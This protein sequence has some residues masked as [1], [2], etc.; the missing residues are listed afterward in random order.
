MRVSQVCSRLIGEIQRY[1][2]RSGSTAL[3]ITHKGD[4]MD[5]VKAKY[6]CVLL[7]GQFHCYTHPMRIYKDI[8][9]IGYEEC[10]ACRVRP[11]EGW[12]FEQGK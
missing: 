6:G 5:Y 2:E 3:I 11:T 1:V 9:K 12:N 8:K 10:V 4:I 7:D